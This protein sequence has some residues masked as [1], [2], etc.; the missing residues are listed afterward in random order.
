[1]VRNLD[2][3]CPRN[4]CFSNSTTLNMQTQGTLAKN[5]S[6][7]EEPKVKDPKSALLCIN[8][9]EF[10]EQNNKDKKNQKDK[11]QRFWE[12]KEQ[13][14]ISGT[15][16]N[17]INTLK[18][19]NKNQDCDTSKIICYN[20]NKKKIFVNI[21]TKSKTSVDLAKFRGGDW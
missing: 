5:S 15:S 7:P 21:C 16:N 1:M 11:K 10:S 14:D 20:Y 17:T 2:I 18:K 4:L 6:R 3:C 12:K 19:K 13:S 9:A 8:L